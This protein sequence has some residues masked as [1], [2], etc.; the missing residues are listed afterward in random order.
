MKVKANKHCCLFHFWLTLDENTSI[1]CLETH[2]TSV[3]QFQ[4]KILFKI[5]T[6]S[7]KQQASGW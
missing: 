7:K 6:V 4:I 1:A 3:Q 5:Y 2:K